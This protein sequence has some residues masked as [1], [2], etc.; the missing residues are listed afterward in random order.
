VNPS[1][2][3]FCNNAVVIDLPVYHPTKVSDVATARHAVR[4]G[5]INMVV[6]TRA[7]MADPHILRNIIQGS[8]DGICPCVGATYCMDRIYQAP[9]A[10][11]IHNASTGR[12]Q[13]MPHDIPPAPQSKKGVVVGPTRPGGAWPQRHRFRGRSLPNIQIFETNHDQPHVS[14]TFDIIAGDMLIYDES[15]DHPALQATEVAAQAGS[16][17]EVMT[18]D[19]TFAPEVIAMNLT[20]YMRALKNRYVTFTLAR[21]LLGVA[22]NGNRLMAKICIDFSDHAT[23][24]GYDQLVVTYGTQPLDDLNFAR[25]GQRRNRGAVSA[26]N[27]HAAIHDA[28]R[29][30]KDI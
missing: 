22:R 19:R 29:R 30:M 24:T 16:K 17:I 11:C 13:T 26:R 20:P 28:Q 18:P 25:K 6:M 10:L 5:L 4:A 3:V 7:H 9:G 1:K 15:V 2:V 12:E 8:E 27:T 14:T 23:M 21:R